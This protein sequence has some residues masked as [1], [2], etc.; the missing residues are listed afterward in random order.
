V[1]A[2]KSVEEPTWKI[3][4]RNKKDFKIIRFHHL[5]APE[6]Q[7]VGDNSRQLGE[8]GVAGDW[9]GTRIRDNRRDPGGKPLVHR[10]QVMKGK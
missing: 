3:N 10:N 7:I 1:A 2:S 6:D 8:R 5:E 9:E 4:P